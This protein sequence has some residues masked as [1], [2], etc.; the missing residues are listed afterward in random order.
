MKL[1]EA[2]IKTLSPQQLPEAKATLTN[3]KKK[4]RR[5][6]R[7]VC[8]VLTFAEVQER[9]KEKVE[10]NK[11]AYDCDVRHLITT[12][13]VPKSPFRRDANVIKASIRA[14]QPPV[15]NSDPHKPV[16]PTEARNS[17]PQKP[18]DSEINAQPRSEEDS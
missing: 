15:G 1:T 2:I 10:K 13:T 14:L 17:D 16:A 4:R 18:V 9:L 3:S 8:E 6:K 12:R 7:S 5:V 11:V